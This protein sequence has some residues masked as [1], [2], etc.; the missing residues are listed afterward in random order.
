MSIDTTFLRRCIASLERAVEGI[1]R[2]DDSGDV[3][4]DIFRAACVKEF[5]LVLEQSG[6]LLRKRLAAYFA[7]NRQ[8]DRLNFKN[9]FRHAARHDLI[10]TDAVERWL[11][12]RD[13][14]N[15]TAHDYVEDFAE[16][17]LPLLPEFIED[18]K[19]LADMIEQADDG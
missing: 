15:D 10:T 3:M 12:Y 11:G 1:E 7:S 4:Y 8:A 2:L 18:A 13:H 9:L 17:T 19:S 6:K 5:E 14:R 16:A